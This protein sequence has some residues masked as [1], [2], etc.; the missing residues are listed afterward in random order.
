MGRYKRD[1]KSRE[2]AEIK[3][4]LQSEVPTPLAFYRFVDASERSNASQRYSTILLKAIKTTSDSSIL[5][6]LE[7]VLNEF[8]NGEYENHWE[9]WKKQKTKSVIVSDIVD[10]N[11]SVHKEMNT[12]FSQDTA[13]K[14]K[15]DE[16]TEKPAHACNSDNDV[17]KDNW[18]NADGDDNVPDD[19]IGG[20]INSV[21]ERFME[22]TEGRLISS[23]R[24]SWVL[25]SGTDVGKVLAEY[26][27]TIPDNQKCL[28]LA[29]WNIL[30]L[31]GDC[32]EAKCLFSTEDWSEMVANFEEEVKLVESEV[33]DSM[34]YF[35]DELEK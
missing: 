14:D 27:R 1:T 33:S 22:C 3:W 17:D 15:N 21:G 4:M 34:Q 13:D 20:N 16:R 24:R 23:R 32:P 30:D 18:I 7:F 8:N 19:K 5:K 31:T 28:N 26:T 2:E 9:S 11:H 35:F 25:S 12:M 10:T 29:Y 6:R